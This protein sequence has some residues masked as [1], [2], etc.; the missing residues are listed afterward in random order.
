MKMQKAQP[1]HALHG[2]RV[3]FERIGQTLPEHGDGRAEDR[4]DQDPQQHRA[5]VVA[6][7]ARDLIDERLGRVR[8]GDDVGDG[9][10]RRDKGIGQT[11]ERQRD[12][13]A[14]PDR[15]RIAIGHGRGI[16]APGAV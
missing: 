9:E 6:P 11:S 1:D 4:Q 8:V 13:D 7:D 2:E 5:F 15:G 12:E 3:G 14:L 10:V 16:A